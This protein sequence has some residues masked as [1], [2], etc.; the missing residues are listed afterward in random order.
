MDDILRDCSGDIVWANDNETLFY[1]TKDSLDRS[2][3]LWRHRLNQSSL[4]DAT[5]YRE[6]DSAYDLS[7]VKSPTERFIY[8]YCQSAET[9]QVHALDANQ[10]NTSWKVLTPRQQVSDRYLLQD[11]WNTEDRK[12]VVYEVCDRNDYFYF[13]TNSSAPNRRIVMA[14][15]SSPLHYTELV[16]HDEQIVLEDFYVFANH[17][18]IL[19]RRKGLQ[20]L[21]VYLFA[22]HSSLSSPHI[23]HF[24]EEAYSLS[25]LSGEYASTVARIE[26]SSLACPHSVYDI[27]LNTYSMALKW[28]QGILNT[29]L[30]DYETKRV[31]AKAR[32][33]SYIP[34]SIVYRKDT[35]H[36]DGS[37]PLLLQGYGSYELCNDPTFDPGK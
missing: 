3:R 19:Q 8:L 17:L 36:R 12:G 14:P 20:E 37:S 28:R 29:R 18:V 6:R 21:A 2:D 4:E 31:W 16:P 30:E 15:L 9:S 7:L 35:F 24:P 25:H 33:G 11:I 27:D 5:I 32:D 22:Q 23:I 13:L 34:V 10:P 26:Y 1:L